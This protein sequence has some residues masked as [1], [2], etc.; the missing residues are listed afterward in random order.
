MVVDHGG[1][2][3]IGTKDVYDMVQSLETSVAD[4]SRSMDR[5][6]DNLGRLSSDVKHLEAT[7]ANLEAQK[8]SHRRQMWITIL[9][10]LVLPIVV[11]FVIMQIP[12]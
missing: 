6:S 3:T 4:L 11:A 12:N 7:T 5:L 2:F 8:T 9:S 10:S 1:T